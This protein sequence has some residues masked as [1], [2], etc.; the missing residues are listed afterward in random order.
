MFK[1]VLRKETRRCSGTKATC[2][3]LEEMEREKQERE[4]LEQGEKTSIARK[5]KMLKR[6]KGIRGEA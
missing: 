5:Q 2:N 4:R 1:P 6:T 3:A